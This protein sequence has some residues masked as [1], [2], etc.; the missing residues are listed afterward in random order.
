MTQEKNG[1]I[2]ASKEISLPKIEYDLIVN[3]PLNWANVTGQLLGLLVLTETKLSQSTTA[4]ENF[5]Q[6]LTADF[7]PKQFVLTWQ[8]VFQN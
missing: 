7:F 4:T 2:I 3:V 5:L 1:Y 6:E 8:Y